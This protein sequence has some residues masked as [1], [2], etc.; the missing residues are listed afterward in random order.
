MKKYFIFLI[1]LFFVTFAVSLCFSA[2]SEDYELSGKLENGIRV[3]EIKAL[4]Y[5]FEPDPIVVGLGERVRLVVTSMDIAHGLAIRE[6][7]INIS[8][9]A[10]KQ[11]SVE[12]VAD[13]KGVFRAYCS[14]YCGPGHGS[15]QASFIVK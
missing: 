7:N 8:I 1:G 9:P 5:R 10:G 13:K 15:M 12:F 3:I 6:F 4:R 11:I 2:V 14:V